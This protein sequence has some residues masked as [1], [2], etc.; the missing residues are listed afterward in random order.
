MTEDLTLGPNETV[1]WTGHPRRTA[2]LPA[3]GVGLVLLAAGVGLAA[4]GGERLLALAGVGLAGF[5][6]LLPAWSYLTLINTEFTV[7]DRAIFRRTGVLSRSVRRVELS[8]VQ[9]SAFA[10][11][12][13]GRLFGYGT[14]TFEV[15][16]GPSVEFDRVHE[17]RDVRQ[18]VDERRRDVDG[19]PGSL[20][21]WQAVRD[22]VVAL[23]RAV[24]ASVSQGRS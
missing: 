9:D 18:L 14:I 23:R 12:L 21:Q 5:G 3:V 10:Q 13:R 19:I 24:D 11:H 8:R 17:P 6:L 7:T 2:V 20:E 16:G 22:E 4:L 15:A 1:V